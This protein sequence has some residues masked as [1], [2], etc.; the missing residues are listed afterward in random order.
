VSTAPARSRRATSLSIAGRTLPLNR[1]RAIVGGTSVAAFLAILAGVGLADRSEPKS[2]VR[3]AGGTT[4]DDGA[5]T[6]VDPGLVR[7]NA[8]RGGTSPF[9]RGFSGGFSATPG[10]GAG[11]PNTRSHGS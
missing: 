11:S 9:S 3:T 7:P 8:G 2:T 6:A 10:A 1:T 5:T 4:A